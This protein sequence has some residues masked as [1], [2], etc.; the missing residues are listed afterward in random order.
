MLVCNLNRGIP[1]PALVLAAVAVAIYILTRHT[2]FGRYLYAIGGNE[3]AAVISGIPVAATAIGAFVIMGLIVTVTGFIQASYFGAT[4]T[5]IGQDM[6]LDAIAACVIGGVD[7]KGGRGTVGG[8]LL[9]AAVMAALLNGLT[10]MN[11]GP[12]KK[13]IARGVVLALAA[14]ADIK[15]GKK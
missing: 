3:E 7:L 11:V 10:L 2:P 9:G 13:M 6:E 5:T 4:T 1:L 15:L 14:W 8:V 12:E